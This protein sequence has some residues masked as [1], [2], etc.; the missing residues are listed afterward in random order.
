LDNLVNIIAAIQLT[1]RDVRNSN[2]ISVRIL[3]K[4]RIRFRISLVWFEKP[5]FGLDVVVI[6]YL[7]STS[8][9]K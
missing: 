8:V 7:H 6:Y 2:F 3:K 9:H 4:T 1:C 5:R